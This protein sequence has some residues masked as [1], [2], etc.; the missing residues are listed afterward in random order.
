MECG[1]LLPRRDCNSRL[2]YSF[3][4]DSRKES[5]QN[6]EASFRTPYKKQNGESIGSGNFVVA[7]DTTKFDPNFDIY[8]TIFREDSNAEMTPIAGPGALAIMA[9][10]LGWIFRRKTRSA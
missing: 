10:G 6:A 4:T 9:L 3:I 5:K 8:A 7:Y 2:R 1:S